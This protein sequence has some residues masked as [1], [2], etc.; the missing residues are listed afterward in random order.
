MPLADALD[1]I[2]FMNEKEHEERIYLRWVIGYQMQM[3]Y[4]EFK[5]NLMQASIDA[6]DKRSADT[7]LDSVEEVLAMFGG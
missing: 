7:I 5:N 4:A 1:L 6:N 2:A 3:G